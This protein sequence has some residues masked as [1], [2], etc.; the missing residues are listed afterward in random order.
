MPT[1]AASNSVLIEN[2]IWIPQGQSPQS[3]L[4]VIAALKALRQPKAAFNFTARLKAEAFQDF[5][6]C[7][8]SA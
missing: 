5:P 2:C 6:L 4:A 3:Q 1:S 8:L 7:E